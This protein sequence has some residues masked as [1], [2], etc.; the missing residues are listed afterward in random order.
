M[1]KVL[2]IIII[3]AVLAG[4]GI[5]GKFAWDH[6]YGNK[7][8]AIIFQTEE[9]KR[10]DL[11]S[12]INASGTVEPE[13]LVNVGAQVSGKIMSFGV[14]ANGK[15]VDYGSKVTKGM[16]LAR[17]DEVLYEA[18]LKE[19]NASLLQAKAGI[20]RAE[21]NYKQA[22]A[23]LALARR[24]W[25]RA[26][27]L[28][29]KGAMAKSDYDSCESAF[30]TCT[31]DIAVT[32]AE[33]EQA[34]A[35][36]AIAEAS[37]IKAKRNLSYCVINSPVDG[38]I[39][40]RRVSVGQTL[41]SNMSAS[42]IFLI[43]TDLKKM[44]VWASVNEADIGAIK[45]GMPVIF[46]VDTFPG[47]EFEGVVHKVRLNATMSQNVVTYVVEISTE[48]SDGTLLPYLTANVRFIRQ[49]R[50]NVLSVSNAA[51][52]YMP[53]DP[54]LVVPEQRKE[55]IDGIKREKDERILW[56]K[57]GKLLKY[58][59]VKSGLATGSASEI[60]SDS[61]KEG[62]LVVNGQIEKEVKKSADSAKSGGRSPFMPKMPSRNRNSAKGR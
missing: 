27:D 47:R 54:A 60:I 57:E 25:E 19:S 46:T 11:M 26:K 61:I 37:M 42:C 35:Q 2:N 20:L 45:K 31:A 5:G 59:K 8:D 12:V 62:D 43:A 44:Q 30:L 14:D 40:D 9:I 15:Q 56:I 33:Q 23:K 51:L 4:L 36:L 21:A 22:K 3:L 58:V 53:E 24:N 34:K 17:I 32:E 28:Y 6:F 48:N 39:I 52:R 1:K 18:A 16:V 29:P 7:S 38:V 13:E 41:V 10:A 49:R 55:F 50:N